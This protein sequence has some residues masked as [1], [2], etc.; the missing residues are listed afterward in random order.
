MQQEQ[1]GISSTNRC[2]GTFPHG[3]GHRI[4][5]EKKWKLCCGL[6]ERTHPTKDASSLPVGFT[7]NTQPLVVT[8]SLTPLNTPTSSCVLHSTPGCPRSTA[9]GSQHYKRH[10]GDLTM[11]NSPTKCSKS[12][13]GIEDLTEILN[14]VLAG[15]TEVRGCLKNDVHVIKQQQTETGSKMAKMDDC[16]CALEDIVEAIIHKD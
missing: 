11:P 6:Y 2:N 4:E 9:H 15:V 16:L 1:D 14:N 12:A 7:A 10:E 3:P 5:M 8:S 13:A